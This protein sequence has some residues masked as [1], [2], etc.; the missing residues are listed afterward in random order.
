[1]VRP[2]AVWPLGRVRVVLV[3]G[4]GVD[5]WS[6]HGMARRGEERASANEW[7]CETSLITP[8]A[9]RGD[10]VRSSGLGGPGRR[11]KT[12]GCRPSWLL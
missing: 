12:R 4:E 8:S 10:F 11:G 1:V 9:K 7:R 6:Q 5:R 3:V 2:Q